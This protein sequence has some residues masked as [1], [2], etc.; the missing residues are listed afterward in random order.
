MDSAKC[1][2]K[3]AVSFKPRAGGSVSNWDMTFTTYDSP[4]NIA[5]VNKCRT[6]TINVATEN[7]ATLSSNKNKCRKVKF[8]TNFLSPPESPSKLD[9]TVVM[10]K[11]AF[12][13]VF[14]EVYLAR[15]YLICNKKKTNLYSKNNKTVHYIQC[16][17]DQWFGY[18]IDNIAAT[19]SNYLPLIIFFT[20]TFSVYSHCICSSCFSVIPSP[21]FSF[22]FLTCFLCSLLFHLS[23][24]PHHPPP[25]ELFPLLRFGP[26]Y[27]LITTVQHLLLPIQAKT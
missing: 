7:A 14:K 24:R 4:I 26:L 22:P 23:R 2:V 9:S 3:N 5:I 27:P 10:W 18:C 20:M 21:S 12:F 6:S 19:R 16:R 11:F 13:W 17:R 1:Y 8:K 15:L 25:V